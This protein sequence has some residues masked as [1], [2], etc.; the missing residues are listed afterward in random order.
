MKPAG[1]D[2]FLAPLSWR[3]KGQS[4][5]MIK[6]GKHCFPTYTAPHD[7]SPAE[8]NLREREKDGCGGSA[9]GLPVSLEDKASGA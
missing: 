5:E 3:L 9:W 7:V 6:T 2:V 8:E 4:A 1:G